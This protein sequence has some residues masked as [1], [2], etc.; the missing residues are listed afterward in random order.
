MNQT[1]PVIEKQSQE[2]DFSLAIKE[3]TAGKKITK[4]EWKNKNIYCLL[5]DGIAM[6]HKE[7]GQFYQWTL[8]E[9]DLTGTDW[10]VL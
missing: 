8:N 3:L 9:G 4:L 5:K 7:D 2:I 10:I 1:S 6:L